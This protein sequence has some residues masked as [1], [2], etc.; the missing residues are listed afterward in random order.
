MPVT[1]L[2]T[3][4]G[5]ELPMQAKIKKMVNAAKRVYY[6]QKHIAQRSPESMIA[7]CESLGDLFKDSYL[8]VG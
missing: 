2:A 8:N 3:L 1:V 6:R 4:H 7:Y 5:D